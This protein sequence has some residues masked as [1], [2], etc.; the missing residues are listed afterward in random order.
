MANDAILQTISR[1][2]AFAN[3]MH[4]KTCSLYAHHN[5]VMLLKWHWKFYL[6]S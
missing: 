3:C 2:A 1:N 6:L 4:L 5:V